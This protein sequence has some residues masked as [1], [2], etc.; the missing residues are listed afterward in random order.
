MRT[1]KGALVTAVRPDSIC[2]HEGMQPGDRLL[3]VN[4]RPLNDQIDYRFYTAEDV[5]RVDALHGEDRIS[6]TAEKSEGEDLGLDFAEATF[7]G[8]RRCRNRCL[9]CFVDRL[10][11]GLRP[12]LSVRDDDYRYS[13]LFGSYVTLTNLSEPDWARIVA[14]R[15]SPLYVSIHATDNDVRRR[16]L[17]NPKAPDILAQLRRLAHAHISVHAQVVLCPGL[18]DGQHLERT[19]SDLAAPSDC[20]ES[21]AIVPVGLTGFGNR[22]EVHSFT[23]DEMRSVIDQVKP[24]QQRFRRTLG[25]TF[26]HLADEFY[27]RTGMP[28]PSAARY[29]GY[30]QYENGVGMARV[31]LSEWQRAR[32]RLGCAPGAR[33]HFTIACGEAIQALLRPMIDHLRTETVSEIH[34]YPIK[35]RFFGGNVTTSGLLTATDVVGQLADKSLGSALVLPRNMFDADG[36]RTLDGASAD[37]ISARLG[38]P[39]V[40]VSSISDLICLIVG[41]SPALAQDSR[42]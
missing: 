8:V 7:D 34:L 18:N 40:V 2:A 31:L 37:V 4:G 33:A 28:L 27:V 15:L 14:Q 22:Q 19:I 42:R 32:R 41:D 38:V 5:V 9:F 21:M 24:W 11:P 29:D 17:G 30:P 25:R 16:L 12:S 39:V 13:F 20:V 1:G 6:F 36:S 10:P 26:V 35:N 23:T 3:S